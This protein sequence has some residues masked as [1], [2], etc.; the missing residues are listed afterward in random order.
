VSIC[1]FTETW[2]PDSFYEKI[3]TN[4]KVGTHS[5]EHNAKHRSDMLCVN[6][7]VLVGRPAY[8]MLAGYQSKGAKFRKHEQVSLLTLQKRIALKHT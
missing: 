2:K 8:P 5:K 3:I 4:R 7:L 6:S 1:F